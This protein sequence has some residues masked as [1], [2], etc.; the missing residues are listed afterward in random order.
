MKSHP[1]VYVTGSRGLIGREICTTLINCG[2]DV[3]TD[4]SC[5]GR[6]ID[7]E[8]E[9]ILNF[10]PPEVS[11]IVHCAAVIPNQSDIED[12]QLL[13]Q[14]NYEIDLNIYEAGK[15]RKIPVIYMSG[16]GLYDRQSAN[17]QFEESHLLPRSPY[18][19]SKMIGE[20][21]FS[22]DSRSTVLRVSAPFGKGMAK[23]V[24]LQRFLDQ[25]LSG[26]PISLWGSGLREQ[27]YVSVEDIADAVYKIVVLG[28]HGIFN[29]AAGQPTTMRAMA[30]IIGKKFGS[31]VMFVGQNDPNDLE[32]V[33][34]SIRKAQIELGWRP[35][36]SLTQWIEREFQTVDLP[37]ENPVGEGQPS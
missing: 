11:H 4:Q 2:L 26:S 8:T 5:I 14:K 1:L 17:A 10:L 22:E 23:S 25:A 36:L 27:D 35:N 31:E 24:V 9:K 6:R 32:R 33:R 13:Q 19:F 3:I 7:L 20:R 30:E 29:I 28:K 21:M 18:F 37:K 15:N 16:C 34:I 12:N